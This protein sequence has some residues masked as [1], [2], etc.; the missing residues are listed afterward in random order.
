MRMPDAG[1][2]GET[3]F[4]ARLRAISSGVLVKSPSGGWVESV[5]TFF[6]QRFFVAMMLLLSK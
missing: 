6:T 4:D 3:F 5:V 2:L 1:P